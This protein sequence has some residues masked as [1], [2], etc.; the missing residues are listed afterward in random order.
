MPG[1]N[2]VFGLPGKSFYKLIR[3]RWLHVR[4]LKVS[5][6]LR[7][8]FCSSKCRQTDRHRH[9]DAQRKSAASDQSLPSQRCPFQLHHLYARWTGKCT[10]QYGYVLQMTPPLTSGKSASGSCELL[11]IGRSFS[12]KK[13]TSFGPSVPISPMWP[14]ISTLIPG[15]K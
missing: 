7:A 8:C 15:S 4:F 14:D 12:A 9:V 1:S 13:V 2:G 3:A 11:Q 5:C 10:V 6:I